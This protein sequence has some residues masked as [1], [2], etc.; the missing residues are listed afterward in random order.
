MISHA[1]VFVFSTIA[2][3]FVLMFCKANILISSETSAEEKY[4]MDWMVFQHV[5][6]FHSF[7]RRT[8]AWETFEEM[9]EHVNSDFDFFNTDDNVKE[10]RHYM[11]FIATSGV[12]LNNNLSVSYSILYTKYVATFYAINLLNIY[13]MKRKEFESWN[14]DKSV[15]KILKKHEKQHLNVYLKIG[16]YLAWY[17]HIGND[18]LQKI[19]HDTL[20]EKPNQCGVEEYT[21]F[22]D[23]YNRFYN[24]I[25]ET[26]FKTMK[27]Y[28]DDEKS[29]D[30][31]LNTVWKNIYKESAEDIQ[32]INRY[33]TAVLFGN[34]QNKITEKDFLETVQK[35]SFM[36]KFVS[37]LSI[38]KGRDIEETYANF[39][40]DDRKESYETN[41][42]NVMMVIER[43]EMI[44]SM[45]KDFDEQ[46][47]L[48]QK[49]GQYVVLEPL[50]LEEV[51][52]CLRFKHKQPEKLLSPKKED[53][54]T[55]ST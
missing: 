19:I 51:Y 31:D 9:N 41:V 10:L 26:I 29:P 7:Y 42:I 6:R 43:N 17:A 33:F 35:E 36:A 2:I 40:N 49:P 18:F 50:P 1:K 25:N 53:S 13:K 34:S 3:G 39:D 55:S 38:M 4:R 24:K 44:K 54:A 11:N 37:D 52:T 16:Q 27:S 22:K 14:T 48:N 46:M 21:Q 30:I 47:I 28:I 5:D 8:E 12:L 15:N 23:S 32:I 20:S 45:K